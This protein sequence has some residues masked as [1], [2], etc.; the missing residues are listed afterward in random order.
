VRTSRT[1]SRDAKNLLSP[2]AQLSDRIED[3]ELRAEVR[4][5]LAIR[6]QLP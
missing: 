3:D 6:S 5:W 2:L 4:D 1:S